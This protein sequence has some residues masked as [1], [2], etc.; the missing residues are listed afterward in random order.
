MGWPT[1]TRR[2]NGGGSLAELETIAAV[3]PFALVGGAGSSFNHFH[4]GDRL[5]KNKAALR[6]VGVS[7]E[8][9]EAITSAVDVTQADAEMKAAFTEG[10]DLK[11]AA[12]L[13][14]AF[15]S[16]MGEVQKLTEAAGFPMLTQTE[17]D[18]D[19]STSFLLA[20]PGT[21]GQTFASQDEAFEAWRGWASEQQ[22]GSM[23]TLLAAST[24]D[25]VQ[26]LTGE[27]QLAENQRIESMNSDL[28]P[29]E[30]VKR[31]GETKEQMRARLEIFALQEGLSMEQVAE[32]F[33]IR[34]SQHPRTRLCRGEHRGSVPRH[35]A[36]IPRSLAARRGR[37]RI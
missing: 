2:E 22:T 33:E 12:A 20:L 26:F 9:I 18:F 15:L 34:T 5:R 23:E 17:N 25:A 13:R 29:D 36:A 3:L 11:K 19:G 8:R 7:E 4:Y 27:G 30:N 37:G 35:R 24:Q 32:A 14:E 1:R 6:M 31:G 10:L 16:T 21:A 28:T